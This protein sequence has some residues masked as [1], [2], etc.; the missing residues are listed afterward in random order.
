[1]HP[2]T[3]AAALLAATVSL[4]ATA[5]NPQPKT[6]TECIPM[7][8]SEGKVTIYNLCDASAVNKK[9]NLKIDPDT[10]CAEKNQEVQREGMDGYVHQ[11]GSFTRWVDEGKA[12]A[13]LRQCTD[14]EVISFAVEL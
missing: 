1:M 3:K 5:A 12:P 11:Q 8:V 7:S 13:P 4:S 2:T 14:D 6:I 9:W 10:K